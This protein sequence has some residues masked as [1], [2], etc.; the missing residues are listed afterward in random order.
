MK[1]TGNM[2]AKNIAANDRMSIIAFMPPEMI[3]IFR[4]TYRSW[5]GNNFGRFKSRT[6]APAFESTNHHFIGCFLDSRRYCTTF[7]VRIAKI[8]KQYDN[9]AHRRF[10]LTAQPF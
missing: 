8:G 2:L 5:P 10:R 7:S 6:L 4:Y 9:S 1:M 3:I